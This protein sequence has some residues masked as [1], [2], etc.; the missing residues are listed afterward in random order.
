MLI[1]AQRRGVEYYWFLLILVF[2]PFGAWAYFF[3]F[4]LKDFRNS[5]EW[6]TSLFHR[7]PPLHELRHRLETRPTTAG[8]LELAERLVELG[9]Y[10]EAAPHL[11]AVLAGEPEHCQALFALAE[12]RRG[13]GHPDQAVEPLRKLIRRHASWQDY[14]AWPE[15]ISVLRETGDTAGAVESSRELARYAP[16]LEHKC[17]LAEQLLDVGAG[18]EARKTLELALEDF[19]YLTGVS[20]RRDRRWVT[21]AKQLLKETEMNVMEKGARA[22]SEI[23][24]T[25]Y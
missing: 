5:Q 7:P 6:L 15:L 12:C 24:N 11:E 18:A 21:R 10:A 14:K 8:R 19:R 20:R 3:L 23:P 9:E 13:S 4:K 2:Q 16:S 1:D 17:L 25:K 22:D